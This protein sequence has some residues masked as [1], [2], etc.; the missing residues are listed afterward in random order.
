MKY[1]V[2]QFECES[3]LYAFENKISVDEV[4]KKAFEMNEDE[5]FEDC[6]YEEIVEII[7][8]D[9][10]ITQYERLDCSVADMEYAF[11]MN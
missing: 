6:S 1:V 3:L 9:M 7:L 11:E 4:M 5:K 8:K 2:F 10:N